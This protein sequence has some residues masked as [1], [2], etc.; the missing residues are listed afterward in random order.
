MSVDV[1]NNV[2]RDGRTVREHL[3]DEGLELSITTVL[4]F[5][6]V[7]GHDFHGNQ[8]TG[9]LG[10]DVPAEYRE[11]HKFTAE[12]QAV[13]AEHDAFFADQFDYPLHSL[14]NDFKRDANTDEGLRWRRAFAEEG[15]RDWADDVHP[16]RGRYDMVGPDEVSEP[17]DQEREYAQE[18]L[19]RRDDMLYTEHGQDLVTVYRGTTGADLE[20]GQ[21]GPVP[22]NALSSW[23]LDP[24]TATDFGTVYKAQVELRDVVWADR[25]DPEV[26]VLLFSPEPTRDAVRVEAP[27]GRRFGG[28][29]LTAAT[30]RGAPP[31][32]GPSRI[33][34][35]SV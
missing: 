24:A 32:R 29:N 23:S 21:V 34:S 13:L 18:W 22:V 33:T 20:V 35:P 25:S 2:L 16:D 11:V 10:D 5:G 4:E 28:D 14:F 1:L 17:T 19:V 9:G 12:Q 30:T 3:A 31:K 27:R 8:W 6:D 26:E 15:G 7:A